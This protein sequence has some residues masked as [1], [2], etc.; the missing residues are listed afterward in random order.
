M[1]GWMTEEMVRIDKG[2][3]EQAIVDAQ[4]SIYIPFFT[5]QGAKLIH[6]GRPRPQRGGKWEIPEI[7]VWKLE[8]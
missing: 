2:G 6:R 5:Q 7:R 3:Q 8:P 1:F 4:H